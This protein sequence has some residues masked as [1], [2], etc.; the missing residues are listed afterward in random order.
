[1]RTL[2]TSG[3][4]NASRRACANWSAVAS[5]GQGDRTVR[6][7]QVPAERRLRGE[8]A[9]RVGV[10][11]D[12]DPLTGRQRLVDHQLGHVEELVDVLHPDDARLP[13]HR[14]ERAGR[15]VRLPDPVAGRGA[16]CGHSR[17][18]G[19]DRLALGQAAGD[20]GELA[21]VADR[22]EVEA[23]GGG[24]VV[25]DPVLHEV[26]AGDVDPVARGGEV[27]DA[28]A[29]AVGRGENR[30]P[31]RAAL[32]EEAQPAGARHPG[33][34]RG[35]ELDLGVGVDQAERVRAD[36]AQPV[37]ARTATQLLLTLGALRAALGEPGRRHE[38]VP[39]PLRG[40]LVDDVE[41][42]VRRHG[43]HGEVDRSGDL[44]D[45]RVCGQPQHLEGLVV[46]RVDRTRIPS[47]EDVGEE[48]VPDRGRS[49]ARPDDGDRRRVEQ[50]V[51][52]HRL[53]AVLPGDPDGVRLLGRPDVEGHRDDAVLEVVVDRIPRLLE[54]VE[55]AAVLRED[56]GGELLDAELLT[57]GGEVLEED[58]A[59]A[60]ALVV[61]GDVE[62]DLGGRRS[63]RSQRPIPMIAPR[64]VMTRATR[65][66]WST[67]VNRKT[68]RSLS[69]RSGAKNR[70]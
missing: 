12:R 10:A 21:R 22:L 52:A 4:S 61:V 29:A 67:W 47:A 44:A 2:S 25:V 19:D 41:D 32:R 11:D 57:D 39:D 68:S 36:D 17:R 1:M 23:H 60:L 34:Q 48:P 62:G 35:V 59:D 56:L 49:P 28:E 55:H 64:T 9:E 13:E 26:V 31:E 20:P 24:V 65:S 51:H 27:G 43:H 46:H 3:S 53:G 66:G 50:A 8:G 38:E 7:L 33:R 54:D 42:V 14:P 18:D 69:S 15:H 30:D 5:G 58:R 37:L 70:R 40:A 45:A 16:V 63:M 6:D